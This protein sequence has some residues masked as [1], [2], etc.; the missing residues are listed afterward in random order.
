MTLQECY[1]KM[2]ANYPDLCRRMG[3]PALAE[4]FSV[5]FLKDTSYFALNEALEKKDWESA[6]RAAHTLKGV[7]ANLSLT[8]VTEAASDITEDL[9]GGR[10]PE[11]PEYCIVLDRAY[12]DA[13]RCLKEFQESRGK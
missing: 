8:K 9:R 12:A 2:Q 5:K 7:A 10:P 6:F 3:S 1:E 13:T 4:R 11:H